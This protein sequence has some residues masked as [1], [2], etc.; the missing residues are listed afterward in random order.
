MSLLLLFTVSLF[1]ITCTNEDSTGFNT[2]K[3]RFFNAEGADQYLQGIVSSLK[4]KNDSAEFV[5][6]FVETYG[7]PLWKDA[8]AFPK[9]DYFTY[10]VPVRSRNS[11]SEIEA[12]WFFL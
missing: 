9:G 2:L 3:G 4:Q 8:V 1:V 11:T 10:A 6:V 5:T 7:Y 12:I